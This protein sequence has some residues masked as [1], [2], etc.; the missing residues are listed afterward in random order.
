MNRGTI[1]LSLAV[2]LGSL[3]TGGDQSGSL[4]APL[5]WW[6]GVLILI[7]GLRYWRPLGRRA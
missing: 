2:I 5:L 3:A 1:V 4:N 7:G 6:S